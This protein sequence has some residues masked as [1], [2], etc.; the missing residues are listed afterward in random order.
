[1][2]VESRNPKAQRWAVQVRV[3][4]SRVV[5][6][7]FALGSVSPALFPS[8][9]PWYHVL[10]LDLHRGT[11]VWARFGFATIVYYTY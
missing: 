1:M 10:R 11:L 4:G 8:P 9:I 3:S 2:G 6:R 5:M 7:L